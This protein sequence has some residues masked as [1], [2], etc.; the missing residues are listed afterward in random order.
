MIRYQLARLESGHV[1]ICALLGVLGRDGRQFHAV[2][3]RH[4][5]AGLLEQLGS[6]SV[7]MR[8]HSESEKE[9]QIVSG[10]GERMVD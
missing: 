3:A 1:L 6:G 5:E 2:F 8:V 7:E 10:M 4:V 9:Q